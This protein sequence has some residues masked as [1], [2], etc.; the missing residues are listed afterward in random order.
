MKTFS[1]IIIALLFQACS[2]NLGTLSIISTKD[3]D[4]NAQHIQIANNVQGMGTTH[5]IF[6][7]PTR[8]TPITVDE[9]VNDALHK[10]GGDFMTNCMISSFQFYIPYIYGQKKLIIEGNVWKQEYQTPN[11][12]I[13]GDVWGKK[14]QLKYDPNTGE[15]IDE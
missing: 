14:S 6:I 10:T 8:F 11:L 3:I 2:H 7:F 15:L 9:I 5:I 4:M 1:I 12:I 13:E